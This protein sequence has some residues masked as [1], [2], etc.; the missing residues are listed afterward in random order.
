MVNDDALRVE[1]DDGHR[2]TYDVQWLLE[3]HFNEDRRDECRQIKWTAESFATIFRS[4]NY[5]DVIKRFGRTFQMK[6]RISMSKRETAG[7]PVENTYCINETAILFFNL[8]SWTLVIW[9]PVVR[10]RDECPYRKTGFV[11]KN[12]YVNYISSYVYVCSYILVRECVSVVLQRTH[13][14]VIACVTS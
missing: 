13:V 9:V 2:S 10:V 8:S 11:Q 3:R 6:L 4:F 5:E 7:A 14:F 1:W 12:I